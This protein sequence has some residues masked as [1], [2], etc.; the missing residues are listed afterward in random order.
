MSGWISSN[1]MSWGNGR[2]RQAPRYWKACYWSPFLLWD[3]FWAPVITVPRPGW[4]CV[5][6]SQREREREIDCVWVSARI[7]AQLG[8]FAVTRMT[9][10]ELKAGLS[11]GSE[12]LKPVWAHLVVIGKRKNGPCVLGTGS[13]NLTQPSITLPSTVQNEPTHRGKKNT[14]QQDGS[15]SPLPTYPD[16]WPVLIIPQQSPWQHFL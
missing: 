7:C 14:Q 10:L 2:M 4:V 15:P 3:S 5:C 9:C 8:V 13:K 6:A 1:Y 16:S 12:S 11:E